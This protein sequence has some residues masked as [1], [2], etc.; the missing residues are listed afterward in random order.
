[1]NAGVG[2]VLNES[3]TETFISQG[4]SIG[5]VNKPAAADISLKSTVNTY[6]DVFTVGAAGGA[7]AV[8]ASVAL[9]QLSP[10]VR[11]Y[12]IGAVPG[13]AA[14]NDGNKGDIQANNISIYN[15]IDST[16]RA[17]PPT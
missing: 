15:D 9:I 4:V 16:A 14:A 5:K 17:M 8:G 3:L 1:M 12:N 11:T 6:A 13:T 7:V 2:V 10:T